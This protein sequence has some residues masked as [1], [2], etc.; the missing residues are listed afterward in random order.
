MARLQ[1]FARV[2]WKLRATLL[3]VLEKRLVVNTL[4]DIVDFE[5]NKPFN[6]LRQ[7]SKGQDPELIMLRGSDQVRLGARAQRAPRKAL[8]CF[9]YLTTMIRFSKGS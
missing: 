8:F 9:S 6:Y 3:Q 1:L 7:I 4:G 5:M 2:E